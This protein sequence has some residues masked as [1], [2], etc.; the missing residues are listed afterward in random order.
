M[1]RQVPPSRPAVG[2]RHSVRRRY[3]P[4]RNP[5][6][7]AVRSRPGSD[8]D[9]VRTPD[10]R[11]TPQA[12]GAPPRPKVAARILVAVIVVAA[13][14]AAPVASAAGQSGG[15]DGVL[16]KCCAADGDQVLRG[17]T[18]G[19]DA[20]PNGSGQSPSLTADR[21]VP[22][23]DAATKKHPKAGNR[24]IGWGYLVTTRRTGVR[25]ANRVACSSK[26]IHTQYGHR[27]PS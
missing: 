11:A 25:A 2:A 4:E 12:I 8:G 26:R 15:G 7:L 19:G 14:G 20:P 27:R 16:A 5:R 1:F 21:A 22:Y 6:S 23:D 24:T 3:D 17:H 9:D 18:D 10:C 13:V